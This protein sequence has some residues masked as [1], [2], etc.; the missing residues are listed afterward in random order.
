M[1]QQIPVEDQALY[2]FEVPDEAVWELTP[3]LAYRRLAMVNVMFH[4]RPGG[5]WVLIDAGLPGTAGMIA[6]SAEARFGAGRPPEAIVLTHGH[7]DHVGALRTLAEKWNVPIYAHVEELPYLNG[8]S[9]YPKPD[10]TVGGG[11][12]SL[13]ANLFP[14]GPLDF[15]TWLRPLPGDG[16]VPF[17]D[18]WQ[19]IHTPGHS[20]GHVSLWR[21]ADRSLIAGDAFITTA[22]ES[23]YAVA[24]QEPELHGPPMYFT[25]D[26]Q[27]A[28]ESVRVLAALE[29]E[30]V[31]T[32]HGHALRGPAMRASLHRLAAE[33]ERVAVPA[34]GRY[35]NHPASV[36]DGSAYPG[37][38]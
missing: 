5:A 15:S 31:V 37:R 17:L 1:T 20:V 9:A 11:A 7:I 16:S 32:G 3:D 25:P 22:Q 29:P 2:G 26:W 36:E 28:A 23:A 34:Q 27:K 18:G 6:R 21:P 24:T 14:R 38:A 10:P 4:G 30:T 13:L 8:Q 35:V 19:W 12:M 33:F